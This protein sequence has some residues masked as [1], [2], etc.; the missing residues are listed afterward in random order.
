MFLDFYYM[1]IERLECIYNKLI[2]MCSSGL[3][4]GWGIYNMYMIND[5]IYKCLKEVFK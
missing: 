2:I 1:V 5:L 3:L 4:G